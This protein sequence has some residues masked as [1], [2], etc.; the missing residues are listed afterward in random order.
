MCHCC[1]Q[2]LD[3]VEKEWSLT[4]FY[5][6]DGVLHKKLFEAEVQKLVAHCERLHNKGN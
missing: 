2:S 5:N 1:R 4:E 3:G 6:V